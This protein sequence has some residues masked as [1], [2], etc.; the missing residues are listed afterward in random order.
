MGFS[1][2]IYAQPTEYVEWSFAMDSD[3]SISFGIEV[4][5][6]GEVIC[7]AGP[8]PVTGR[9]Q[10]VVCD[11]L[12]EKWAY[13][14]HGDVNIISPVLSRDGKQI[15]FETNSL[16]E[17][18]N[19]F[20]I[21]KIAVGDTVHVPVCTSPWNEHAP[22]WSPGGKSPTCLCGPKKANWTFSSVRPI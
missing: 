3:Q 9:S 5:W 22:D 15:V 21:Y 14:T 7:C 4:T 11:T 12:G 18:P 17:D 19:N 13:L 10:V 8:D 20:D 2:L 6:T 1:A 16:G